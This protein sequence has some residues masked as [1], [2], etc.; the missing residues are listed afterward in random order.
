MNG[1]RLTLKAVPALR[2][3]LRGILPETLAALST[4]EIER[5]PVGCGRHLQPLADGF[6]IQPFEADRPTLHLHGEPAALARVDHIGEGMAGGRLVVHGDAGDHVGSGMT[7]GDLRVHGSVR[8]LAG[9]ELAGGRLCID[10]DVGEACGSPRPGHLDGMKGG[11]LL[12]GGSAGA[13]L[14]DRMRRGTLIVAGD[15]GEHAASRLVA[16]TL[17][18]GGALR[19]RHAGWGQRRGSVIW[20]DAA[21]S[22][23]WLDAPPPGHVRAQADAP[24][25]WALIARDLRRLGAELADVAD[26][27]ESVESAAIWSTLAARLAA[28]PGLPP[29]ARLLG[30]ITVDGRGE[31]LLAPVRA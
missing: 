28:L 26:A 3:D 30:D 11:L 6:D 23:R 5:L 21:T 18:I 16:G 25:A 7:G 12:I 14:A 20:L 2:L 24:V 13:R 1:H 10:G 29:P 9:C 22:A 17:V 19:G 4:A 27:A 31:W 8:D 15:V